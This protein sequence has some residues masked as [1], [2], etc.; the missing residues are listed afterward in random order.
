MTAN[1]II[2]CRRLSC[3]S[4]VLVLFLT[5]GVAEAGS[6]HVSAQVQDGSGTRIEV[7]SE[8]VLAVTD[9]VPFNPISIPTVRITSASAGYDSGSRLL[10]ATADGRT[11]YYCWYTGDLHL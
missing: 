10:T 7:G 9:E 6:R 1:R 11:M 5:S 4:V 2:G 8:V 3:A